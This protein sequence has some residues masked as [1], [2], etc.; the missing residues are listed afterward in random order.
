MY[1]AV[2]S[3]HPEIRPTLLN[4]PCARARAHACTA[5]RACA[6]G[7]GIRTLEAV[8][9]CRAEQATEP[10]N[11]T[12]CGRACGRVCAHASACVC[13]PHAH[14]CTCAA[15]MPACMPACVLDACATSAVL[16]NPQVRE[17]DRLLLSPGWL[18]V[19]VRACVRTCARKSALVYT[20]LLACMWMCTHGA[21]VWRGTCF[22]HRG[23][24]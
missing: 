22:H 10:E 3:D 21:D 14:T 23:A 18:R 9:L 16:D 19:C 2:S 6:Q 15:R 17:L 4:N 11:Q 13:T 1:R 5:T 8:E 24:R 12:P 20:H 7:G